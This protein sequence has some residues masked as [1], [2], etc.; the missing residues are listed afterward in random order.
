MII[1]FMIVFTNLPNKNIVINFLNPNTMIHSQKITESWLKNKKS[2][3]T[4]KPKTKKMISLKQIVILNRFYQYLFTLELK[5]KEL[6]SIKLA[7]R[8]WGGVQ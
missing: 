6:L 7:V 3:H 1:F 8:A 2:P 5:Q 4:Q